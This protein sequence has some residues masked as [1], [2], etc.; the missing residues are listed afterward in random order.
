V[1]GWVDLVINGSFWIGAALGAVGAIILLDP[2]VIDPELGWRLA[3]FIGAALGLVILILRQWIPESPRW[4]I[5]HGRPDKA[6]AIV[7]EIEAARRGFLQPDEALPKIHL[8]PR[9]RHAASGGLPRAV[10]QAPAA[11]IGGSGADGAQA[12]FYNAIFFTYAL[13]LTDFYAVPSQAI[14]WFILPFAAGNVLGPLFLG[15]L[16]DTLGRRG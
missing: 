3:F 5:S 15:R 16:F 10:R 12:F 11:G 8:R 1:R 6:A 9:A 7:A 4:L 14:G 13:I 2:A